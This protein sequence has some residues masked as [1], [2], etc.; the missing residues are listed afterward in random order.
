MPLP[1]FLIIGAAKAGTSSLYYYLKQHPQVFMS[2]IKEP[3]F[4]AL[5]GESLDYKGP[6]R[7]I[8]INSV[9]NLAD[10]QKLFEGVADEVAVGEASPMYLTSPKA[11]ANIKRYIPDVK[12]I[13]ILRNPVDRA[14]SSYTHLI[15]E[16]LETLSFEAAVEAEPERIANK[17][18]HLFYYTQNGYYASQVKN[19]LEN[20][21]TENI[22]IY[23]YEDLI[24]DTP[25]LVD[26][27]YGFLG[28][29]RSFSPDLS[30]R[31]VSGI[32]KSRFLHSLF[33]KDNVVKDSL[34][35]FFPKE[36]RRQIAEDVLRRNLGAKPELDNRMRDRLTSLYRKDILELQ[37]VLHRD[38][39]GWLAKA[40]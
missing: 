3:K 13:A 37:D 35:R 40:S 34:K 16:N 27:L 9:N 21:D 1:N 39:S 31:N 24:Q 36:M 26:E 38:L 5:E 23:L 18:S 7:G 28:I 10:Y 29:D 32:P 12:L 22:K 11:P 4:F 14:F 2:A 17:W 19:Y 25:K 8:N 6:D 30:K 33:R 15:R 20:Y